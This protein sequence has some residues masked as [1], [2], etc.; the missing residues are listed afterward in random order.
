MQKPDKACRSLPK[1][2]L[3]LIAHERPLALLINRPFMESIKVINRQS[4]RTYWNANILYLTLLTATPQ[5]HSHAPPP[6]L[7]ILY[8]GYGGIAV[9][10]STW[11]PVEGLEILA[12]EPVAS[13][14]SCMSI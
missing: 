12:E 13:E 14:N 1:P 6:T 5:L 9:L 3:I 8:P 2:A 7:Q 11:S 4:F 10:N